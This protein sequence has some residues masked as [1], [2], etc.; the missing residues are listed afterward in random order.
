MPGYPYVNGHAPDWSSV[1]IQ[2]ATNAIVE[3][4]DVIDISYDHELT[5]G[6][7]RGRRAQ[8]LA[9]TRGQYDATGSLTLALYAWRDVLLPAIVAAGGGAGFMEVPF[10]VYVAIGEAPNV[11]TKTDVLRAC[12]ITKEGKSFSNNG[13]ALAVKLDLSVQYVLPAGQ[14][15]VTGLL[16]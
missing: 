2:F 13:D 12:R 7:L 11:P 10:D 8:V 1:R 9:R 5:P 15:P 14:K 16:L 6:K 4:E 3:P